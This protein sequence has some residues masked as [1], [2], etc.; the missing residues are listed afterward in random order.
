MQPD[1]A[2]RPVATSSTLRAL[3]RINACQAAIVATLHLLAAILPCH[4]ETNYDTGALDVRL[5]AS[6]GQTDPS[7]PC[8]SEPGGELRVKC[9][10]GCGDANAGDDPIRSVLA[11]SLLVAR[12]RSFPTANRA[13]AV[14]PELALR[15]GHP[16][17]I[18]HVPIAT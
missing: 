10:C 17:E 5:S 13:S 14:L 16:E 7:S 9:P 12:P 11:K 3:M 18:D 2:L 4:S 1:A 15:A 8:H 6:L